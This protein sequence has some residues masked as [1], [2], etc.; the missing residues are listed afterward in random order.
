MHADCNDWFLLSM[1]SVRGMLSTNLTARLFLL[2]SACCISVVERINVCQLVD[3]LAIALL[4]S[5]M[6]SIMRWM[7]ITPY[8]LFPKRKERSG[9]IF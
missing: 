9:Q 2:V 6:M 4:D 5:S 8:K 7:I 3:K 1:L